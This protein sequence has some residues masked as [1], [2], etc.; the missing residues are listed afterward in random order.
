MR[1]RTFWRGVFALFAAFVAWQTLTPDPQEAEQGLAIARFLA[2]LFFDDAG[3]ADKVAHFLAYAALGATAG[4]GDIRLAGKRRLTLLALALYGVSLEFLQ[5]LGGVR[6]AEFVDA[7]AN[8]GGAFAGL[9]GVYA[10]DRHRLRART[11]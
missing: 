9:A 3:Y 10:L 7:L 4:L 6:A 11:A 5:G 2:E 8:A 1:F